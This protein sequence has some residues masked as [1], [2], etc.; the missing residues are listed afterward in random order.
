MEL[1]GKKH[2]LSLLNGFRSSGRI[3]HALLFFGA[4][5]IGKHTLADHTAMMYLCENRDAA[6]CMRCSQCRRIEQHIH[7]DVVYPLS[8][9]ENRTYHVGELRDFIT[10]CYIKPNDG[11]IRVCIFEELDEMSVTC[12]NSLLKF[13]EEPL[14]FNRYIFIADK[15]SPILQTVLS[16]VVAV[17]VD[18]A[19]EDEF[20][21]ALTD[22]CIERSHIP[23]L[24][25]RFGGNIGAA[26]GFE[27]CG[28][29]IS[30][31]TAAIKAADALSSKK[32]LD[33]LNAFLALKT[34][35]EIFEALGILSDIFAQTS[36][37]KAGRSTCG[38]YRK[39]TERLAA[40]YSLKT[41]TRLYGEAAR[42]YGMS[43]TNPNVKLFAAECSSS[44]FSTAEKA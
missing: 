16:R 10:S 4:K 25:E 40:A 36:A 42:L 43:F 32:E 28:E 8:F 15:K 14:D 7:P 3:P 11:D 41:M 6:P 29:E 17:E 19:D 22:N 2:A 31:L 1:Y 35:G 38:A 18:G 21:R 33:C 26:L 12:Q 23:E 5:G 39:Q 37:V 34:R 30:Y 44:L 9:M 13:I 24:Y 20:S 27:Q